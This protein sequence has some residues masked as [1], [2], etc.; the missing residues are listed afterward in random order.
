MNLGEAMEMGPYPERAV[1][2]ARMKGEYPQRTGQPDCQAQIG[3][4][5]SDDQLRT[6]GTAQY[7]SGSCQ[8][9][10]PGMGDQGMFSSYQAGSVPVGLYAVQ[11]ENI[12]PERLD[13]P[14]CQF[15]MK[16]GDCKFGAV[17]KF[18]HP[19]ERII[20]TPNCALN[21]LGLPLRPV[22]VL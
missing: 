2:A 4:S 21:S 12:F 17:C 16:T 1:A 9:G 11:R 5:S 15:Y 7:Y 8:S 3:S 22:S 20:P 18:H 13:Q 6:P 14:E 10:A 19:R